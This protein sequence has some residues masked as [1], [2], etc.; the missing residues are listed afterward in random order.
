MKIILNKHEG[1]T[2]FKQALHE[3]ADGADTLSVA[4]SYLQVSGWELF[5]HHTSK[6]DQNKMRIVCTDQLGITHPAAVQRAISSGVQVRNFT[7][8]GI[9]H[10]K[11]YLAHDR[12]GKATRFLLGSANLSTSAFTSSVE[13]GV[14][15]EETVGL[16]TL[17][18]W[19]NELFEK[20]TEAFTP[21]RL[22]KM[23]EKWKSLAAA[24]LLSRLQLHQKK[25]DK[26]KSKPEPVGPEDIDTLEDVFATIQL[27]IGLL[28]MDYAGNNVRN[29][30]KLREVL[31]SPARATGKQQSELKLLGYMR[32]GNLTEL[33]RAAAA[34]TSNEA[35]AR[36]WCQWLQRTPNDELEAINSKLLIAKRVFPQFWRLKEDVR[37]YF[38]DHAQ[39]PEDRRTLQTIELLCNAR[40]VVQD[41]SLEN[42]RTLSNLLGDIQRV[43]DYIRLDVMDYFENKGTRSWSTADRRV[44]PEA[45]KAVSD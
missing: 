8:S 3:L 32:G 28:N 31:A 42:M 5:H 21:E 41:L 16:K 13:A 1:A 45:W 19:F 35:V 4:V 37:T 12:T 6:L 40:D 9:Y 27:P 25:I 24:R 10:P 26:P 15:S 2:N 33:G 23:E 44:L 20:R 30:A 29:L 39:N 43:P 17:H 22:R 11:V 18:G 36:L 14:L 7:G 34:L 38:L